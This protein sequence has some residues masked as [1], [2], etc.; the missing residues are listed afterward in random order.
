MLKCSGYVYTA[1]QGVG[2]DLMTG[3]TAPGVT[4]A[5]PKGRLFYGTIEI[6]AAAVKSRE[7]AAFPGRETGTG[8]RL[9]RSS[10]EAPVMGVE[11]GDRLV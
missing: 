2:R 5:G 11:R 7:E 4:L 9:G 3:Y 1:E 8:G 10:E 6:C